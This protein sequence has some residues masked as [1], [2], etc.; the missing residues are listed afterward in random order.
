M[1]IFFAE[2]HKKGNLLMKLDTNAFKKYLDIKSAID[3]ANGSVNEISLS[4]V[5]TRSLTS[6]KENFQQLFN[7]G[8]ITENEFNSIFSDATIAELRPYK[9]RLVGLVDEDMGII[10][11]D[12]FSDIVSYIIGWKLPSISTKVAWGHAKEFVDKLGFDTSTLLDVKAILSLDVFLANNYD[13]VL[14]TE[15]NRKY[16]TARFPV[17]VKTHYVEDGTEDTYESYSFIEFHLDNIDIT[18]PELKQIVDKKLAEVGKL[19][20]TIFEKGSAFDGMYEIHFWTFLEELKKNITRLDLSDEYTEYGK[21][22]KL[23]LFESRIVVEPI[24]EDEE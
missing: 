15:I 4:A 16:S 20:K 22:H 19:D 17:F 6:L 8:I 24:C 2:S 14:E 21:L 7:V 23:P 12:Y 9:G 13:L 5:E 3:T 10:S 18:V 1:K 11:K